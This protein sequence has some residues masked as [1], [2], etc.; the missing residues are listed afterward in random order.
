MDDPFRMLGMAHRA[1]LQG[2]RLGKN[3]VVSG[4]HAATLA[5]SRAIVGTGVLGP[6]DPPPPPGSPDFLDYRGLVTARE[7][8]RLDQRR[9]GPASFRLGTLLDVHRGGELP[10]GLPADALHRHAAVVGPAGS[11]KT[12][13]VLVPWIDAALRGGNS[14]VA[15]DVKGDLFEDI[16]GYVG[17]HPLGPV[18]VP[19]AKWDFTDPSHSISWDWIGETREDAEIDAALTAI[20]GREER[21]IGDPYFYRRDSM[22]LRGLLRLLP[23]ITRA[24][25]AVTARDLLAL[26]SDQQTLEAL[27]S[28]YSSA[29]GATDLRATLNGLSSDDYPKAI[30]GVTTALGRLDL[31]GVAA[32][33]QPSAF[34]LTDVFAQPTLLVVAAPMKGGEAARFLSS[35]FLNLLAQRL[36]RRFGQG[37]TH[38]FLFVDEAARIVDRFNFEEVLSISRSAGVSVC[39]ATQDVAQFKDENERSTVFSNCATF[40]SLA[41][42]SP[43][44]ANLLSERLGQHRVSSLTLNRDPTK[45]VS[46]TGQAIESVPVLGTR[47]ITQPP[48]GPRCAIAHVKATELGIS[49]KPMLVDLSL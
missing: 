29:P 37:G 16:L 14:V 23:T 15:V 13:G 12:A 4:H 25:Q 44:S 49:G 3:A 36:Y 32:V 31:A 8:V 18:G 48:F 17:S 28:Q 20:L 2:M 5:R 7:V 21:A 38:L 6:G 24:G 47:E 10:I 40:V 33:T 43:L 41:G 45:W 26:L 30:S 46:G 11:G 22:M 34:K 39:L 19:G 42:V 9:L 27:T 1:A 35:L